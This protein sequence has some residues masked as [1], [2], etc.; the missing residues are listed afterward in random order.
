MGGIRH[1][2]VLLVLVTLFATVLATGAAPSPASAHICTGVTPATTCGDCTTGTHDHTDQ[3]GKLYCKSVSVGSTTV[4]VAGLGVDPSVCPQPKLCGGVQIAWLS[5][6]LFNPATATPLPPQA[7]VRQPTLASFVLSHVVGGCPNMSG[8]VMGY[9]GHAAGTGTSAFGHRFAF[10]I[11][12]SLLVSTGGVSGVALATPD[13][14][15]GQSC[16]AGATQFIVAGGAVFTSC[17][18][19]KSKLSTF[20]SVPSTLTSTGLGPVTAGVHSGPIQY[21]LKV[22]VGT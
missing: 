8:L 6:P 5:V 17:S 3:D 21:H 4:C 7:R 18:V 16:N 9:C 14:L 12:G 2:W 20:S 13:A 19:V 22:C 1:R 15:G 10:V 11:A